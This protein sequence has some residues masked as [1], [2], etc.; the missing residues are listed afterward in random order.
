MITHTDLQRP[1]GEP[2]APTVSRSLDPKHIENKKRNHRTP[3]NS[4]EGVTSILR[5]RTLNGR[6]SR[7]SITNR[8]GAVLFRDAK[9][10]KRDPGQVSFGFAG[11][12]VEPHT[13]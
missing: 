8:Q 9:R 5:S 2:K 10:S 1:F 3:F 13:V 12:Q 6:S 4:K 7:L 11:F